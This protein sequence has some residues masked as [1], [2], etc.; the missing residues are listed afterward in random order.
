MKIWRE[1]KEI[2]RRI[3]CFTAVL[4]GALTSALMSPSMA[5]IVRGTV[6]DAKSGVA[7][8]RQPAPGTTS[9]MGWI[10]GGGMLICCIGIPLMIL[11]AKRRRERNNGATNKLGRE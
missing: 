8:E 4:A 6:V 5:D 10:I 2:E 11:S 3:R 7:I 1:R 9:A